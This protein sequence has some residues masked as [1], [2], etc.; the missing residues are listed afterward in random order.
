MLQKKPWE[1]KNLL[2]YKKHQ[3]IKPVAGEIPGN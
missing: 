3:E 2:Q 1:T